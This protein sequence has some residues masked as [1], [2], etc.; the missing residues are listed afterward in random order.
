MT[1]SQNL[2]TVIFHVSIGLSISVSIYAIILSLQNYDS[3]YYTNYKDSKPLNYVTSSIITLIDI[4]I[5]G[6]S[7]NLKLNMMSCSLITY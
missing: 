1:S 6:Y 4:L 2:L 3:T 7:F 5:G